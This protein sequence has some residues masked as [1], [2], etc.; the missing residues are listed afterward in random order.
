MFDDSQEPLSRFRLI[1]RDRFIEYSDDVELIFIELPKFT[2][3]LEQRT[4]SR[5]NGSSL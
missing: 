1:E 4:A 3:Q 2:L 5:R